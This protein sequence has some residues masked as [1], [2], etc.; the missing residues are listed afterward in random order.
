MFANLQYVKWEKLVDVSSE[1]HFVPWP[2]LH[3]AVI[4]VELEGHLGSSVSYYGRQ[5]AI[6]ITMRM[7]R[8]QVSILNIVKVLDWFHGVFRSGQKGRWQD[9]RAERRGGEGDT[10]LV[11]SD[12]TPE[13][14]NVPGGE[15]VEKSRFQVSPAGLRWPLLAKFLISGIAYQRNQWEKG[16]GTPSPPDDADGLSV[17]PPR[18][19]SS[20]PPSFAGALSLLFL[21]IL[22][23]SMQMLRLEA[24]ANLLGRA[25]SASC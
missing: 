6:G 12:K 3:A 13:R 2:K 20:G 15:S 7:L 18:V 25:A 5:L 14:Q 11:L 22:R 4:L 17:F 16:M 21:F 23:S 24:V 8:T 10:Y 1:I 19:S 9:W